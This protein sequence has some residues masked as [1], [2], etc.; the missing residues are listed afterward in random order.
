MNFLAES[1][2]PQEVSRTTVVFDAHDAPVGLPR[3]T[4]HRG[5]LV[6]FAS[7]YEEADDL[8]EE[9]LPPPFPVGARA[10]R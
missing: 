7:Q 5:I 1:I 3:S 10:N 9:L 2:A 4:N 6:R 8:I